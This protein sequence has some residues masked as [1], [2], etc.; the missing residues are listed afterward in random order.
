MLHSMGMSLTNFPNHFARGANVLFLQSAG[1]TRSSIAHY[2]NMRHHGNQNLF[3]T[4]AV[5]PVSE[6]TILMLTFL[7][8]LHGRLRNIIRFPSST[9]NYPQ[10]LATWPCLAFLLNLFN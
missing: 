8:T 9:L 2:G 3:A 5:P 1:G 6:R 4:L 7:K 10:F